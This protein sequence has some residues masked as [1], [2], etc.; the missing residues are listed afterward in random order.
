MNQDQRQPRYMPHNNVVLYTRMSDNVTE[1]KCLA[2]GLRWEHSRG[3]RAN[4]PEK[5]VLPQVQEEDSSPDVIFES[6]VT[7]NNE[8]RW[9][10]KS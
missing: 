6:Y 4:T 9:R 3:S 2:C 5:C 7:E 1:V 8:V 10:K